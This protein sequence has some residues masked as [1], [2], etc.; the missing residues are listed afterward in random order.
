M[1]RAARCAHTQVMDP[2]EQPGHAHRPSPA[3]RAG[4]LLGLALF[5]AAMWAAWLGW[6]TEYYEVDGVQHGPYREWQ[7]VGC[8]LSVVVGA[9]LAQV[10][11]RST[12]MVAPLAAAA[13]VGFAVPWTMSAASTDD[14]GL[15]VVGAVMLLVGGFIA[16]AA[17]LAVTGAV[18][19]VRPGLIP[20]ARRRRTAQAGSTSHTHRRTP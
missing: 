1:R 19:R 15:F 17:L 20:M 18:L 6:D 7:V 8:G 5:A 3:R 13:V 16:L 11:L 12:A 10:L 14:S 2:V 4:V 9:V